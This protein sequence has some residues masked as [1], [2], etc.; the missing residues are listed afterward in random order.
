MKFAQMTEGLDDEKE[1][2]LEEIALML[3]R[4]F[5]LTLRTSSYKRMAARIDAT[6]GA[7]SQEMLDDLDSDSMTSTDETDDAFDNEIIDITQVNEIAE[8]LLGEYGL[9]PTEPAA[10]SSTGQ[11]NQE[12]GT[13]STVTQ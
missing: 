10:S 3:K 8:W 7:A 9:R 12:D 4:M 1:P 6:L 13:S 2:E 5:R 11:A